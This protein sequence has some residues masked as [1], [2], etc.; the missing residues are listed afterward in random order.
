[1]G[2]VGGDSVEG[3]GGYGVAEKHSLAILKCH[4]CLFLGLRLEGIL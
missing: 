3:V 2:G 4:E 1:M